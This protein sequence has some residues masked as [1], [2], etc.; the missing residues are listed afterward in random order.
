MDDLEL[1]REYA[2]T[3]SEQAF[4]GLVDRYLATVYSAARRQ[5]GESMAPD[6]AQAVFVLLARKSAR[7]RSNTVLTAWL[8]T[9]TRLVCRATLR[10]EI[11]R[12]HREQEAVAMPHSREQDEIQSAWEQV[13]PML[14]EALSVLPE[15]DR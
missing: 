1:L 14:D 3:G 12:E 11:L 5:V 13:E 6:V 8:L 2:N 9:T 4:R 7:L 15:A 10:K